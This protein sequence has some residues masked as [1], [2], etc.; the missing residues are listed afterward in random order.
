MSPMLIEHWHALR[1]AN[2]TQV[3][4]WFNANTQGR[5]SKAKQNYVSTGQFVRHLFSHTQQT[6]TDSARRD[7]FRNCAQHFMSG[8]VVFAFQDHCKPEKY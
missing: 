3:I 6:G 8:I 4:M 5:A 2:E 7:G 1:N